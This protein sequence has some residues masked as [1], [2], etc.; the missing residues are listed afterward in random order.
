MIGSR[1]RVFVHGTFHSFGVS[2]TSCA[3]PDDRGMTEAALSAI[4]TS[5]ILVMTVLPSPCCRPRSN[6]Y[7]R[8]GAPRS[9]AGNECVADSDAPLL[10][11]DESS[12]PPFETS[13]AASTVWMTPMM[14]LVAEPAAPPASPPPEIV[15]SFA[16]DS[17]SA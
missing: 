1:G 4:D 17:A 11:E 8:R 14:L 3:A 6:C 10:D 15:T 12:I 5:D 9:P 7:R 2:D 13:C 16:S